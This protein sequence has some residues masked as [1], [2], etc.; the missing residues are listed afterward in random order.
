MEKLLN[1]GDDSSDNN[2]FQSDV[3]SIFLNLSAIPD[4]C[5]SKMRI[6]E[7]DFGINL[8][9]LMKAFMDR[10]PEHQQETEHLCYCYKKYREFLLKKELSFSDEKI[11]EAQKRAKE[12]KFE[13][14][15]ALV[16]RKKSIM[17]VKKKKTNLMASDNFA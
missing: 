10:F 11:S 5:I 17:L 14:E 2:M 7:Q 15:K 8:Q 1:D 12:K 13:L 6:S 3:V 9:H 16:N 4:E